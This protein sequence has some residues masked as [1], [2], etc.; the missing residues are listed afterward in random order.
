MIAEPAAERFEGRVVAQ[1]THIELGLHLAA[2]GR[3]A[4]LKLRLEAE[5]LMT[6]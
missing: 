1:V 5:T 3:V 6:L 2:V 4:P